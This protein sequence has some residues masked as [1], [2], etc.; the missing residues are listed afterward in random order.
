MSKKKEFI[1]YVNENWDIEW[2]HMSNAL[3]AMDECRCPLSMTG[4][5]CIID[6]IREL[7]DDFIMDNDLDEDWFDENFEDEEE[8]FWKLDGKYFCAE[9]NK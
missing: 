2:Y 5:D 3:G 8:V 7:A 1:K 9:N 4:E 6:R